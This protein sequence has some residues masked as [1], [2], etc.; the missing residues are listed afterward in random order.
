MMEVADCTRARRFVFVCG[1]NPL[2]SPT[3]E[4]IFANFEGLEVCSAGIKHEAEN[5][6]TDELVQW[7]DTIFV[8]EQSQRRKVQQ[9]HRAAIGSTKIICL[10]IP[11]RF[12]FMQPQL[13]TLL[14]SR[15]ARHLG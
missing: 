5:P 12:R 2:R 9:R 7:A 13:V 3:A 4:Q 10:D 11:D 14:E 8:M 1:Q 15:M 6:L